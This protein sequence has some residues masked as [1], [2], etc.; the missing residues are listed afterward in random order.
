MEFHSTK[1][2]DDFA[3]KQFPFL[4][5]C[6]DLLTIRREM[7]SSNLKQKKEKKKNEKKF[8]FHLFVCTFFKFIFKLNEAQSNNSNWHLLTVKRSVKNGLSF[9][10]IINVFYTK[11]N[12]AWFSLSIDAPVNEDLD[13]QFWGNFSFCREKN[14]T[15]RK[16]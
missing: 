9:T 14:V 1:E 8:N 13:H 16:K 2:I 3:T 10:R 6:Q 12:P 4:S 15:F 5:H 11:I 7:K